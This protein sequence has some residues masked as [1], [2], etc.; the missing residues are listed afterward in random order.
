MA[1]NYGGQI[2]PKAALPHQSAEGNGLMSRIW[3]A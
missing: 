2:L 3:S 1:K